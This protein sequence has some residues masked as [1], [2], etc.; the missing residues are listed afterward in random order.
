MAS[1]GSS[2]NPCSTISR[3]FK[4]PSSPELQFQLSVISWLN[5]KN[6]L[7]CL[8]MGGVALQRVKCRVPHLTLLYVLT[9][10][11]I[12]VQEKCRTKPEWGQGAIAQMSQALLCYHGWRL[13][14]TDTFWLLS[15]IW[16][17]F[18]VEKR[19]ALHSTPFNNNN[20]G[21]YRASVNF[22]CASS[23]KCVLYI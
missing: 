17:L 15:I 14:R 6:I 18:T 20:R 22:Y 1:E 5:V 21:A 11:R 13:L 2:D 8:R 12:V 3:R 19:H 10:H 4:A 16:L 23:M 7:L 9:A